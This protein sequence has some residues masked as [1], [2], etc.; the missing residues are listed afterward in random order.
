[1]RR[2]MLLGCLAL[3]LGSVALGGTGA[4]AGGD[5]C[6]WR[7]RV[8]T[9]PLLYSNPVQTSF[10]YYPSSHRRWGRA[11]RWCCGWRHSGRRHW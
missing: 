4:S 11:A 5:E 7:H 3:G 9:L 2:R 1:M 6:C 8:Y 10:V